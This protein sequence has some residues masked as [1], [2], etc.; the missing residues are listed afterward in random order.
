[1]YPLCSVFN[2]LVREG[3]DHCREEKNK[4]WEGECVMY[5]IY[6]GSVKGDFCEK[7]GLL[8]IVLSNLFGKGVSI[9]LFLEEHAT[10]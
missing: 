7:F 2:F 9:N 10:Y 1:M 5:I 3:L 6:F 8:R 4:M